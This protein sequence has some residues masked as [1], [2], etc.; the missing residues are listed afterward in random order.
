VCGWVGGCASVHV[1][2]VKVVSAEIHVL[3][4]GRIVERGRH[5]ELLGR[6]N[7]K[8]ADM[9]AQQNLGSFNE[10]WSWAPS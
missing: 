1:G 2:D 6:P 3:E 10:M 7:S 5:F 9:W 4:D 8:Y